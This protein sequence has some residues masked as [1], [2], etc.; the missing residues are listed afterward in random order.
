MAY[1]LTRGVR[2]LFD[3]SGGT[4]AITFALA[5]IPLVLVAGVAVDYARGQLFKST[6]QGA[7]DAAA[8]AGASAYKDATQ[9]AAAST[10]ANNSITASIAQMPQHMGAITYTVVPGGDATTGFTMAI[11]AKATMPTTLMSL[12]LSSIA[13][14][15]AAT[16]INPPVSI[17]PTGGGSGGSVFSSSAADKN[18]IY[19]YIVPEDG[20]RPVLSA[21]NLLYS[22][23][24]GFDNSRASITGVTASQ[25]LGFALV[26]VTGGLSGYG[27]NGYNAA[28]GSTHTFYSSI[29][30]PSKDANSTSRETYS[31]VTKN[32]SAQ[33]IAVSGS[34]QPTPSSGSCI[35]TASAYSAP[36]CSNIGS[37]VI[38]FFWNDMGGTSDDKDFNDAVYKF[39]CT[40][41]ASSG[42]SGGQGSTSTN[43][44]LIQ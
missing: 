16:A 17:A 14:G 44:H 4:V 38:W 20:S 21:N 39:S 36:S 43:V 28:Q 24:P 30:P 19:W 27:T 23:T 10:A 2:R 1:L 42:G 13:I 25:R 8:L 34:S 18:S 3:H 32:C 29:F 26:N 5:V 15:A 33:T 6:L 40:N 22:N 7:V 35:S 31:R 41:A 12:V 9:T 37:K 11:T